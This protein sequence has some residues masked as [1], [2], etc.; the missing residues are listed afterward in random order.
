[1]TTE[2]ILFRTRVPGRRL[3]K[4]EKILDRLGL[5]PSDAFNMLL[6]QIELHNG[7]P[8][9]LTAPSRLLSA[10]EQADAWTAALGAY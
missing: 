9:D 5:K 6:A 10:R 2:I 4:A 1:M 7:V 3:R 8:F